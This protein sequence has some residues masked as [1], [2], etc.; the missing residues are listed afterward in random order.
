MMVI[1]RA[2]RLL[3]SGILC[4]ILTGCMLPIGNWP[5]SVLQ[6]TETNEIAI[7]QDLYQDVN[8]FLTLPSKE[9]VREYRDLKKQNKAQPSLQRELRIALLLSGLEPSLFNYKRAR[10]ELTKAQSRTK[11]TPLITSYIDAQLGWLAQLDKLHKAEL[12]AVAKANKS[13]EKN[14]LS[15]PKEDTLAEQSSVNQQEVLMAQVS[16]LEMQL[17]QRNSKIS[18]LEAK[19]QALSAIERSLNQRVQ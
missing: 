6:W 11:S 9:R 13:K 14:E 18:E 16:D 7:L 19:I 5:G 17:K 15:Q 8:R 10:Q 12:R 4:L 2:L 1:N 3:L